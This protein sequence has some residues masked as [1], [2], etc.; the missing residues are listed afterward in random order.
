MIDKFYTKFKDRKEAL[1]RLFDIIP[2]K[3][4]IKQNTIL[5]ALS[6]GGLLLA[7]EMSNRLNIPLDFLF[8]EPILAPKN[9]ECEVA[10]VSE[11]MDIV[12]NETLV[13]SFNITYDFIY[14]EAQRKYEEKVLPDIYKFRKGEIMSSLDKKNVLIIDEG[15]E[16][17]LTMQVAIKS[18]IKKNAN[19]IM[20]ASPVVADDIAEMLE[21]NTDMIYSLYRPKH[22]VNTK[23]YYED[24]EDIDLSVFSN[25]LD[26][27]LIQSK[28][29]LRK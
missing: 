1:S 22:F 12:V 26:K 13:D 9:P 6:Q 29:N 4:M 23:Y 5:I 25:I 28:T 8:T 27:A 2:T 21:E 7:Y 18:C 19:T 17:G 14:G 16:T 24:L 15:I 3:D 20:I 11:S 10:I